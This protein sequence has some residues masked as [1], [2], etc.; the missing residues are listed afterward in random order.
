MQLRNRQDFWSGV[1]FIA[2]G[3]GFAWKAAS[4]QMGTAARMGPGYFPF[5]LGLVLAVLGAI[6]LLG[7]LAKNATE[8]HVDKFDWRITFLVIGSVVLYALIL[9]L[10][11]VYISVFVLVVASSLASH[12]FNLKV[13][14]AN[15]IFLVVFSYLAFIKGLGLIFPLWPSFL[16][17][18]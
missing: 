13:A 10:L 5:A 14:V 12:E 8:T 11:G 17:M 6:V 18:N 9:K 7:S 4:Y 1:M 3:L 16:G 15:G 2:L